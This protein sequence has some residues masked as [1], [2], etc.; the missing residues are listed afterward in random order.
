MVAKKFR[1]SKA[2]R[3][4]K[5]ANTLS[6][7]RLLSIRKKGCGLG[8]G[9][10]RRAYYRRA[11]HVAANRVICGVG[12]HTYCTKKGPKCRKNPRRKK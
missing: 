5:A 2:A 7:G 4:R 1:L 10:K 9:P 3:V 6:F 11:R 8:K 12:R